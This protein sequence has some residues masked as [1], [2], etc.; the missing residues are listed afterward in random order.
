MKSHDPQ[1]YRWN[2]WFFLK[3]LDKGLAYREQA[4]V[5]WCEPCTTVLANEQVKAGRCGGATVP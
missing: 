3:F 1:Y 5:N 4:P 2:Q